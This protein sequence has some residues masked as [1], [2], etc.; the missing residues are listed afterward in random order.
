MVF[1]FTAKDNRG[2]AYLEL[3]IPELNIAERM[4]V[5]GD[6]VTESTFEKEITFPS[7]GTGAYIMTVR[8][9]DIFDNVT[10]KESTVLVTRLKDY[11]NMYLV[12]FEGTDT[13]LLTDRDVWGIPM[14][15]ERTEILQYR[16]RYYSTGENTPIRFITSKENFDICFGD[17]KTNPGKMTEIME[18]I[19]PIILPEKGYYEITFNLESRDYTV[20]PYTPSDAP[21]AIGSKLNY[22]GQEYELKMGF[23]GGWFDGAPGWGGPKNIYELTQDPNNLYRLTTE[24]TYSKE[25]MFDVNITPYHPD[26]WWTE[27][28]WRFDGANESFLTGVNNNSKRVPPG[29]YTFEFDTHLG[30]SK[31]LK[32][33]N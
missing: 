8:V 4:D 1:K 31:L 16:A 2:L 12:D 29:K 7:E 18:N 28:A 25:D 10:E 14:P 11:Q 21:I 26:G 32:K 5:E 24:L 27:P 19:Q 15:I 13:H 20:T 17:D 33:N 30:Q 23:V 6:N 9:V 3:T 22:N